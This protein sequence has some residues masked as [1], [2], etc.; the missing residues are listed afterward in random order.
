MPRT[1]RVVLPGQPHHITHRGNNRC[2][3]F[4]DEEDSQNCM[5]L[6]LKHGPTAECETHA[7]AF[8]GNH[9]HLLVTPSEADG[10]ERYMHGFA[11]NFARYFNGRYGRTGTLWEGRYAS[12]VIESTRYFF[13]CIRYI[14]LNPVRASLVVQPAQYRWSSFQCN[15]LGVHDPLVTPHRLYQSLAKSPELRRDRYLALFDEHLDRDDLD[16]IRAA[17]TSRS[18]LGSEDFRLEAEFILGRPLSRKKRGGNRK[19]ARRA[20]RTP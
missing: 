11:M 5:E 8:M 2:P 17:T 18:I 12:C 15:A 4:L 20:D 9:I 16:A 19:G 13:R 10:L 14:E 1:A 3:I 7:Y 6:L